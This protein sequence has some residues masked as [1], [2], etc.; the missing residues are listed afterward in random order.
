VQADEAAAASTPRALAAAFVGG[1]AYTVACPPYGVALVAWLVPAIL[2]IPCR[3]LTARSAALAGV[4]F[5]LTMGVGVTGWA[6]HASLAYFDFNR[7]SAAG[8]VLLVW[9]VYGGVPFGLLFGAYAR[10][11]ARLP[12]AARAPF[13][14]WSWAAMEWLRTT[15]CT[16][17]PWELLGHTQFR[18]L[19]LVQIA[20][21]GGVY[22]VSFVVVLVSVALGELARDAVR[23]PRAELCLGRRLGPVAALLLVVAAYGVRA[24]AAYER[25]GGATVNVAIVQGNVPNAFRWQRAHMERTL[26]T[27]VSLTETTRASAPDLIVWPENAVDFYLEREPL[28]RTQLARAAALAPAGLL[29]GSPRLAAATEA[30]N[31]AQL[32]GADGAILG[33]YDKQHLVPFAESRL[34][35]SRGGSATEPAEPITTTVGRLG[36]MICYE[37]LFPG[38]VSDL[39]RRGAQVLV[40]LTNDSWLDAGDGAALEQH[41]SMTVFRAIET[42]RDLVRVASGGAS[43]FIDASGRIRAT[44]RRDTAGAL[45]E[46]IHL[47][48]GL[49]PYVRAGDAW[50]ALFGIVVVAGVRPRRMIGRAP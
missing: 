33:R 12:A 11:G 3:G 14:A 34:L 39:V 24:Q 17:M 50:I 20:D 29:I 49:T 44:V 15:L 46:P 35:P 37:V 43:G 7:A 42:R 41:F 4:V 9:L 19:W 21:L 27:Y 2:L 36:T 47:R 18:A 45:V 5:A 10:W 32:L 31:S 25:P 16:G 30:R 40:N 28:L 13:A 1:L 6:F 38:L 22:A 48:A 23:I 8:F 26:G